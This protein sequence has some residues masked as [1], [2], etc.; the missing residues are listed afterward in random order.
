M[1]T[2]ATMDQS[3]PSVDS[4]E[5]VSDFERLISDLS[6]RFINLKASEV[7]SEIREAQRRVCEF[8]GV[9]RSVLWQGSDT[10]PAAF[11]PSHVY[12]SDESLRSEGPLTQ[13]GFPWISQQI[14]AGRAVILS[15]I[16]EFPEEAAVDLENARRLGVRSSINLP[17]AVG[18]ERPLGVFSVN[19]LRTHRSWSDATVTELRLLAQVFAN[20]IARKRHERALQESEER[21]SLA[22][23]AA[24]AGLWAFDHGSNTF[25]LTPKARTIFA[26]PPADVVDLKRFEASVHPEDRSLV[27]SGMERSM[28]EGEELDVEYRIVVPGERRMRWIAM[29]GR[30]HRHPSGGA[31]HLMGALL[32]IT[33]QKRGEA[34]VRKSQAR[35]SASADLAGLAYYEADF[36]E[37]DIF[38]DDRFCALLGFPPENAGGLRALEFWMEHIHPDDRP[39]VMEI[40]RQMH[41]GEIDRLLIEYRFQH[42]TRGEIWIHHLSRV[43]RRAESGGVATLFGVMRD[44]TDRRRREQALQESHAEITLLKERLQAETDYLRA[45]IGVIRPGAI[46]TGESPAIQQ[47]LRMVE[48]VAP[49]DSSVLIYGETGTGKE[50]VAQALHRQS[51]RR[52]HLMVSINCAALPSG[53][54][55]SELFGRERGAFTGALTRQI[56]RFELAD[57][58]TLFLDE[59]GEL[60]PEVQAKLL[61]VLESGE[62]ERLGN[63]R[64]CKADVRI[65]AAT[66]RDLLDEVRKGR[67]REDLYYRLNVFP[68]RVPPL[69][70]RAE[71]IPVLV[72]AFL[73]EISSRM[74]KKITQVPKKTMEALQRHR[75]PGNVRE[76]RNVIE[77]AAILAT[78]DTLKVDSI[79]S[80]EIEAPPPRLI[81][82]ERELILRALENSGWRIKGPKGA[83]RVLGLNPSTLY[84]RM[85]KLGLRPRGPGAAASP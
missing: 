51:S 52:D 56:G 46:V 2:P 19:T 37:R 13:D 77:H 48:R 49:T 70:E 8:L 80:A 24:G 83:A 43:T 35:L 23:E 32:D 81:D 40:R 76:L 72:W 84:S 62:F 26:A 25:W 50:L 33:A 29:R 14:M 47:V 69:R 4:M 9:D 58:S 44:I 31:E 17:L 59:I 28:R 85:K 22:A 75:W 15:S 38:V 5:R 7:D 27:R 42:P 78:G 60:S 55:E 6:T 79:G 30:P 39:I 1:Y 66:N 68:I 73:E 53:L 63:S 67:F 21:L 65:I 57:R 45:E 54:V 71:D 36:E 11:A 12:L 74:G 41:A 61:R 10:A 64:T 3:Q 20:A 18:G 82:S 34:A 16:D